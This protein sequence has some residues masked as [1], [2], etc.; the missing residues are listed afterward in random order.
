MIDK[1]HPDLVATV[2]ASI[3]KHIN[4]TRSGAFT[5]QN[6]AGKSPD[7][8][9][10]VTS[11]SKRIVNRAGRRSGKTV[12]AAA[13]MHL[14]CLQPPAAPVGYI[15]I[16]REN[17]KRVVW[18]DLIEF[19][20][21]YQLGGKV[22]HSDLTIRHEF[23]RISL[24]GV[25]NVA[26]V[27]KIRSHKFK[28]AYIDEM[29]SIPEGVLVSLLTQALRPTLVDY[30]GTLVCMGTAPAAKVGRW[31]EMGWGS[32][33]SNYEVHHWTFREN[34]YLPAYGMGRTA[35]EIVAE[36]LKEEG[37]TEENPTFRREYLGE[38]VEDFDSRLY[39]F[40]PAINTFEHL[41]EADGWRYVV[42]VD[43]GSRDATAIA[44]WAWHRNGQILYLV[45]EDVRNG[46][47]V[48]DVEKM[49]RDVMD[50][51]RPAA[52]VIDQGGLGLMIADSLRSHG[53]PVQPA[54]KADKPGHI[55]LFNSDL[56]KGL[57][58]APADSLFAHDA[59]LVE[60][61]PKA[62]LKDSLE[63]WKG[64]YHSDILDAGLY[65]WREAYHWREQPPPPP[66]SEGEQIRERVIAEVERA[67]RRTMHED[68]AHRL[69]YDF[70]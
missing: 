38:V 33:A 2:R 11:L 26:E 9:A 39:Q 7:Q 3:R 67:K 42:G 63:E 50:K 49:I 70:D 12:G 47:V 1:A 30:N 43:L 69:G 45:H 59:R 54:K 52:I 27:A 13:R 18:E 10:F 55:K 58:K 37:W 41:P 61:D 62:L 5:A 21:V 28:E 34:P 53:L 35:D 17:S 20:D 24:H 31:Y 15:S 6:V 19:N 16:T 68:I 14:A 65:G 66:K 48:A 22:N 8:F 40:D 4:L 60:R 44:V 46:V 57:I 36:I 25:D 56:R 23:G 51:F 32:L 29:Q 64:G